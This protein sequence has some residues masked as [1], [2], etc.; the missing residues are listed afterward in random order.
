M[1][2]MCKVMFSKKILVINLELFV[3]LSTWRRVGV[4][5]FRKALWH[6]VFR[7]EIQGTNVEP[8][9]HSSPE[10]DVADVRALAFKGDC[11]INLRWFL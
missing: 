6:L 7:A 2:L 3:F 10:A 1:G 9:S 4:S 8:N 5:V 11:L